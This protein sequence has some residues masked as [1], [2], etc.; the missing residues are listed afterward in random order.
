[1]VSKGANLSLSTVYSVRMSIPTEWATSRWVRPM[2]LRNRNR[3]TPK[4]DL[5]LKKR[6]SRTV[7][8]PSVSDFKKGV[9]FSIINSF[10]SAYNKIR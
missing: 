4:V 6:S 7:L 1:M 8:N 2:S 3:K 10:I 9:N 5:T